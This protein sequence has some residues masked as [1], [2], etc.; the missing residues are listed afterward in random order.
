MEALNVLR[1]EK[2]FLTHAELHGRTTAF[3]LGLERMISDIRI[4]SARWRPGGQG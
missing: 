4:A 2:G 1:I 3:D